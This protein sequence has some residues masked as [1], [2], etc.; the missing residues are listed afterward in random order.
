MGKAVKGRSSSLTA[1]LAAS[2]CGAVA[3][4]KPFATAVASIILVPSTGFL[5]A[6]LREAAFYA[7]ASRA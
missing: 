7:A 6:V 2:S 5:A 1:S 4:V 3:S